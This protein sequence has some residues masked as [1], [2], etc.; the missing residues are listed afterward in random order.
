[1]ESKLD[2]YYDVT[3]CLLR[4]PDC[5]SYRIFILLVVKGIYCVELLDAEDD[6]LSK[7][8]RFFM[9]I[10]DASILG[11]DKNR[12]PMQV[13]QIPEE[14]RNLLKQRSENNVED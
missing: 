5:A 8:H 3:D 10:Q 7:N 9:K 6:V 13:F 11:Y 4:S 1:M 2:K 14:V 12:T